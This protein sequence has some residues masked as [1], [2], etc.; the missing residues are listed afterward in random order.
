MAQI[1]YARVVIMLGLMLPTHAVGQPNP[2]PP[3]S[4]IVCD[5]PVPDSCKSGAACVTISDEIDLA[6]ESDGQIYL[7]G[8]N[9]SHNRLQEYAAA[10]AKEGTWPIVVSGHAD[11]RYA[12]IT[13][14]VAMLTKAGVK[15]RVSCVAP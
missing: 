10:W 15:T 13:S 12:Q 11:T 4:F 5:P 7:N 8:E 6:V 14:V 3:R 9:V 1:K 2:R